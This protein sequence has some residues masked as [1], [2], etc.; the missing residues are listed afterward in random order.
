MPEHDDPQEFGVASPLTWLLA[1]EA[2]GDRQLEHALFLGFTLDLGFFEAMALGPLRASGARVTVVGDAEMSWP[3]PRAVR[4]A[5]RT[6]LAGLAQCPGAFHPKLVVLVGQQRCL[7][8]VGSGNITLAGWQNN[9]ELW[10]VFHG[11]PEGS[12]K[13]ISQV[14]HWMR[15]LPGH[16]RLSAGVAD[17]LSAAASQLEIFPS[18][19]SPLVLDN[20]ESPLLDQIPEGAVDELRVFAPFHDPGAVAL[21]ALIAR[22]APA[23]LKVAFQPEK[24]V[25][26]GPAL[27][28]ILHDNNG[29]LIVDD[30]ARYRHGKLVEWSTSGRTFTLTGSANL[31]SAALCRTPA[32]GGNCEL[33]VLSEVPQ[34]KMPEGRFA[35][36]TV[37]ASQR[38][39]MRATRR[40]GPA[41]LGATLIDGGARVELVRSLRAPGVLELSPAHLSPDDWVEAV[42]VPT[43]VLELVVYGNIAAGSRCRLATV[44]DEGARVASAVVFVV[45]PQKAAQRPAHVRTQERTTKPNELLADNALLEQFIS[46][47]VSLR[48]GLV[49]NPSRAGSAARTSGRPS[50]ETAGEAETWRSYVDRCSDRLGLPLVNFALGCHLDKEASVP[51]SKAVWSENLSGNDEESGLDEDSAE[52]LVEQTADHAENEQ[53]Q[54]D[55][56]CL[57]TATLRRLRRW[58]KELV[59]IVG[60][61]GPIERLL[62]TRLLLTIT[63]MGAWRS[64]ELEWFPLVAKTLTVLGRSEAPPAEV[65]AQTGSLVAVGLALLRMHA[66][67]HEQ[68]GEAVR[69]QESV[70]SVA[71]LLPAAEPELVAE[72]ATRL[73]TRFGGL[74]DTESVLALADEIVQADPMADAV[75]ALREKGR[76]AHADSPHVLH[77]TGDFGNPVVAALDA[78]AAVA[79]GNTVAA[80][81]SN[82][83]GR[84]ALLVWRKP[85]LYR[86]E[87]D[88]RGLVLWRQYRLDRRLSLSALAHAR[89]FDLAQQ[90]P[91]RAL[92]Q[93][94]P[95]AVE[96]IRTLGLD[97]TTPPVCPVV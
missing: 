26:D 46:D 86:V 43:G 41:L 57:G 15:D 92:V 35:P 81:A 18:S 14:S 3:D 51:D 38:F 1:E 48:A 65:E 91:R 2:H 76:E 7:A 89:D 87:R 50:S 47:L 16:V 37:V 66:P 9:A 64:D 70:E 83:K 58:A 11:T 80:W 59:E 63:A 97:P 49:T 52:D 44:D 77:V 69:Y 5:G 82:S 96:L 6:Y 78:I 93:P 20:L 53:L 29:E 84:W 34:S 23:N 85:D 36:P 73:T 56:G 19:D 8:A 54:E 22:L 94:I 33:A 10:T 17:A 75:L 31:S 55:P 72:Y 27:S 40:E 21:T 67:R 30:E 61:L 39:T 32:T 90:V 4:Q 71:H 79:R 28:R 60:S 88:K 42:D 68:T 12:P 25:L 13:A 74:V 24:T 45:D 62:A 95:D